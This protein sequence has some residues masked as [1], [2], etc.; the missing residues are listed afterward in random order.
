MN[1]DL[2]LKNEIK[3]NIIRSGY[4]MQEL[5][6]RMADDYG[7]SRSVSNFSGKLSRGTLRYCEV[8]ELAEALGFDL[9][10]LKKER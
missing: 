3:A 7:W 2:Q 10:W 6:D 9:V 4:T 1:K 5:V 8:V